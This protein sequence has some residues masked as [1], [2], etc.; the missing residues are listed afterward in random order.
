MEL[1]MDEDIPICPPWWPK[2]LWEVDHWPGI[3]PINYPPAIDDIMAAI[4]INVL[5]YKM[6]DQQ[7]AGEIREATQQT[8]AK[9]AGQLNELHAAARDE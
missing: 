6:L 9:T 5:S 4:T 7:R 1:A 3:G 8:I 2:F